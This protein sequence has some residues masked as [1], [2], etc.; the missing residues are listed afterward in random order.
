MGKW[1]NTIQQHIQ[2]SQ[3][4][5]P[6][7]AGDDN[8]TMNRQVN[9]TNTKH[10][11]PQKKHRLGTVRGLKSVSQRYLTLSSDVDRDT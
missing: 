10:K 8:A 9:M 11:N 1:Q 7:P 4:G 3:E 6:F 2:Q 5:S